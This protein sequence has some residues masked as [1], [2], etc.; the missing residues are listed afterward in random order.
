MVES[1]AEECW[2]RIDDGMDDEGSSW[3]EVLI[4]MGCAVL[5][6]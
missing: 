1:V 4:E 5:L 6:G 3:R 2:R